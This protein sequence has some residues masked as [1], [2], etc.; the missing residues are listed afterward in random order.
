MVSYQKVNVSTGCPA[1]FLQFGSD[2]SDWLF[3]LLLLAIKCTDPSS[4]GD[5]ASSVQTPVVMG[6]GHQVYRPQL[7]WG[8]VIKCTDPSCDGDWPSSVQTPVV[9]G[10]GHQVYRPQ[11]WWGL[12]IKCT[13]PSCDGDWPS[14]VQTPVVMGTGHQVY[15]PQLWWGL[16]IKCT[17]PSCDG[18]WP[19]SV[20]T[21]VVM[22]TQPGSPEGCIQTHTQ[23]MQLGAGIAARTNGD[24]WTHK[25]F[26]S[27]PYPCDFGQ[28]GRALTTYIYIRELDHHWPQLLLDIICTD[29]LWSSLT[30]SLSHSH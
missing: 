23:H 14:S 26:R 1:T 3:F 2:N 30:R 4:D 5:W 28:T 12:V 17:D 16:V 13:D 18:D 25:P 11:S 19:S 7:W 20:Q 15:R 10:T 29:T 6:T 9:M 8:L 27:S 22:G 24:S 21:P